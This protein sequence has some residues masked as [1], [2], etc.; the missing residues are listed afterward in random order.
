MNGHNSWRSG[1]WALC[2]WHYVVFMSFSLPGTAGMVH[3][4]QIKEAVDFS[5]TLLSFSP[6]PLTGSFCCCCCCYWNYRLEQQFD[7]TET[8]TVIWVMEVKFPTRNHR[9]ANTNTLLFSSSI[10][11]HYFV[12]AYQWV[13]L[14]FGNFLKNLT[15][16][17]GSLQYYV[18]KLIWTFTCF[19]KKNN[20]K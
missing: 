7:W 2:Y 11:L 1:R 9:L 14:A 4:A 6:S 18:Y 19:L 8:S 13:C 15:H 10:W 16:L 20:Y 17:Y 5:L 12:L 3:V